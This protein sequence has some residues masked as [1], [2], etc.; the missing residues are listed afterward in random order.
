M[1]IE[2]YAKVNYTLEVYGVRPDGFH[3]LRS[4]VLPISLA[5]TLDIEPAADF[6]SNTG[7][8]DDLALRAARA[9]KPDFPVSVRVTKRIPVGGGLGGG[10]A[11][12]AATLL[13][14]NRLAGLGLSVDE[15]VQ[16]G[17][18]VG[19]DVPALVLAHA[20]GAVLME[21]RGER[22]SRTTANLPSR[23]LVLACPGVQSST[24]EVYA[25]AVCRE[26]S[27]ASRV[28]DLQAP[29]IA[30]H[31]E[32]SDIL[33]ALAATGARG[34]MMSGSGSTVYGFAETARAAQEIAVSLSE[35][36]YWSVST[37]V[38]L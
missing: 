30:L 34:S 38:R 1:T 33:T 3:A 17:A 26:R 31:P 18:R 4:V 10:S 37:E 5:D 22:V 2:A 32:I 36:G 23:F 25:R 21:G 14:V 24:R 12:A 6:S 8:A 7:Y 28:N 29:A 13:A 15:L 20:G 19:S 27:A 35:R 11:D 16:V 9:L